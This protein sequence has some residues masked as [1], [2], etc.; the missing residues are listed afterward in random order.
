MRYCGKRTV[1]Y[2]SLS[3]ICLNNNIGETQGLRRTFSHSPAT[4][5]ILIVTFLAYLAYW[6]Q[7]SGAAV[8]GAAVVRGIEGPQLVPINIWTE[9]SVQGSNYNLICYFIQLDPFKLL[10]MQTNFNVFAAVTP[11]KIFSLCKWKYNN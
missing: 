3:R 5:F 7:V 4:V 1:Y 8:S 9:D 6:L 11:L 2:N 10:Q